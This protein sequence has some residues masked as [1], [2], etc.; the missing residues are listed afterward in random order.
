[1]YS[2]ICNLKAKLGSN[3][4]YN[5]ILLP[6]DKNLLDFPWLNTR[7]LYLWGTVEPSYNEPYIT[8][9]SVQRMIFFI[10][11]IVRFM[12][13]TLDI[14][15]PRYREQILPVPWSFV[16]SSVHCIEVA[17]LCQEV[18]NPVGSYTRDSPRGRG[19]LPYKRLMGMCR[20][21]GS[22]FQESC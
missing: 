18:L 6:T 13:K 14:T 15:K 4:Y 21:M 10:P 19:V 7:F 9:S 11:I 22:H 16:K 20:W 3:V 5:I 2:Q 17:N 12:K 1:M 8:A